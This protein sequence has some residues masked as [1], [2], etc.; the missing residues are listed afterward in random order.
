MSDTRPSPPAPSRRAFLR[1]CTAMVIAPCLPVALST[2]G[3]PSIAVPVVPE[4]GWLTFRESIA[5]AQDLEVDLL[6][7]WGPGARAP[8]PL[9]P[10]TVVE[11]LGNGW[12]R[13]CFTETGD[14]MKVSFYKQRGE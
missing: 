14:N 2:A 1:C 3:A 12:T 5:L 7:S 10:G 9:P 11:D 8:G 4:V 6:I 13:A